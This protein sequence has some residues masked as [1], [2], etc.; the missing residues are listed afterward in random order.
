L[1]ADEK[2]AAFI[3]SCECDLLTKNYNVEATPH[4]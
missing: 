3:G 4:H 1:R 2:Q